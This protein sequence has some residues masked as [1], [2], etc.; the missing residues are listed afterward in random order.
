MNNAQTL[1]NDLHPI[2]TAAVSH[3]ETPTAER[4][5]ALERWIECIEDPEELRFAAWSLVRAAGV[6]E[7]ELD[8]AQGADVLLS[9]ADLAIP[10]LEKRDEQLEDLT[11]AQ[12]HAKVQALA[13][14]TQ[15]ETETKAA[16]KFG[17]SNPG[18]TVPL[19]MIRPR[20]KFS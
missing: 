16:P 12:Q 9:I 3:V 5:A 2:A 19:R 11:R 18:G 17:A 10:R 1:E 13:R 4:R 6:L 7:E 14:F 8:Q 15:R 20:R